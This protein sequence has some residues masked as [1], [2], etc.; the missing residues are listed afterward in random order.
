M[1]RQWQYPGLMH[2]PVQSE[3]GGEDVR[4]SRT[5]VDIKVN[6]IW[7]YQSLAVPL[8]IVAELPDLDWWICEPPPVLS[9]FPRLPMWGGVVEPSLAV[10]QELGWLV[11]RV[12][13]PPRRYPTSV[14]FSINVDPIPTPE[15]RTIEW[16][17]QHHA[18]PPRPKLR[19]SLWAIALLE[20]SIVVSQ[21][22]GWIVQH[23][24]APPNP[25]TAWREG[26]FD[27]PV[28]PSLTETQNLDWLQQHPEPMR[29]I[30]VATSTLPGRWSF[31]IEAEQ[32]PVAILNAYG[33]LTL[34]VNAYGKLV[35]PLMATGEL[36]EYVDVEGQI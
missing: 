10:S 19:E 8:G 32:T 26:A 7:Q 31:T 21:N 1:H 28:E 17:V 24:S 13:A 11:Q 36:T 3:S 22:L 25:K 29:R 15:D 30:R 16:F 34:Y 9:Q 14:L 33:A 6:R 5:E 23:P 35:Q 12:D 18:V 4:F 27:R 2:P 20:P